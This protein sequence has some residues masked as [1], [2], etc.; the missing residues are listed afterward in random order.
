MCLGCFFY[1]N[2]KGL[3]AVLVLSHINPVLNLESFLFSACFIIIFSS[4]PRSSKWLLC[5]LLCTVFS[6]M[7]T[8][9]PAYYLWFYNHNSSK[10]RLCFLMKEPAICSVALDPRYNLSL[11]PL[12]LVS[13]S[14]WQKSW[15]WENFLPWSGGSFILLT[16]P[17][18]IAPSS[19]WSLPTTQL[20]I[21][22]A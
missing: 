17:G 5:C 6:R 21:N 15:T 8:A 10:E 13:G 2:C 7:C 14:L 3:T 9:F 12:C 1:H 11:L 4:T 20:C 18:T 19:V 22:I 16:T